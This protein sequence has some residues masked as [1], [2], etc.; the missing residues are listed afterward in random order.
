M[1]TGVVGAG[2][3][4]SGI[5]Q[6]A[7]MSGCEVRLFDIDKHKLTKALQDISLSLG[8]FALKGVIGQDEMSGILGTY[9]YM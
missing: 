4:G 2:I 7:A 8:K 3:M 6:L 5:A 1:I 9:L